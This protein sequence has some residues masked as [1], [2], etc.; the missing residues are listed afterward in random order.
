M[1]GERGGRRESGDGLCCIDRFILGDVSSAEKKGET[2]DPW[3]PLSGELDG[4]LSH[5]VPK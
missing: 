1:G 3:K 2:E 4:E 5:Q